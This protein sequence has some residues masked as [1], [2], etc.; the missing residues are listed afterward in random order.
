MTIDIDKFKKDYLAGMTYKELMDKYNISNSSLRS[1]IQKEKLTRN[2][3]EINMGNQNAVGNNGGAPEENKNAVITGEYE[4][5]YAGVLDED[6]IQIYN[7][8]DLSNRE[9]ALINE[10]KILC[11][12]E[13]RMLQRIK[14]I[15]ERG[16][17][18]IINSMRS[19]SEKGKTKTI[20]NAESTINLIQRIEE[21]L[22]R[23][24][25]AKRKCI[26][27][28]ER[29]N[30]KEEPLNVNVN[31]YSL[32]ESINRQLGGGTNEQ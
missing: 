1:L 6:E 10:Y 17:D 29:L 30:A 20:T 11:I 5:I 7:N 3:S 21:G 22:T 28:L 32:L 24:Q 4:Q 12:R 15:K 14:D 2:K 13:K 18:M 27:S 9:D 31:N 25:E 19:E 8:L 26:E 16:K 23:V